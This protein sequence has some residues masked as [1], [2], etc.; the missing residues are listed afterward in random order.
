ML[1]SFIIFFVYQV[2]SH[3]AYVREQNETYLFMYVL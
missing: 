3:Y 1:Y 2:N